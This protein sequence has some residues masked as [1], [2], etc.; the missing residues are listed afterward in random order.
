MLGFFFYVAN[1]FAQALPALTKAVT[2]DRSDANSVFYLAMTQEAM[3]HPTRKPCGSTQGRL[4]CKSAPAVRTP[5]LIRRTRAY[6]LHWVASTKA[7]G[8]SRRVLQIDPTSR[9]GHYEQGRLYFDAGRYADAAYEGGKAPQSKGLG[10][11]DRQIHF[12]LTR[13]YTKMGDA[14]RA[15]AHRKLFEAS[16][17]HCGDDA[18]CCRRRSSSVIR[19]AGR[20]TLR[21][22]GAIPPR[23]WQ[24]PAAAS[25]TMSRRLRHVSARGLGSDRSGAVS[26]SKGPARQQRALQYFIG[27]G[28]AGRSFLYS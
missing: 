24:R 3:S 14:A 6:S 26:L 9:D 21:S 22:T 5:T 13:A 18:P 11:T 17:P 4:H 16:A 12:L 7:R 23:R 20:A 8:R 25:G 28:A 1:D 2:L 15:E 19:L 27:S 10:T